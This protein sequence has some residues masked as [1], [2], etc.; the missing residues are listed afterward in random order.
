MRAPTAAEQS[1]SSRGRLYEDPAAVQ[2]WQLISTL[3]GRLAAMCANRLFL[4]WCSCRACLLSLRFQG[5]TLPS[6]PHSYSPVNPHH[7]HYALPTVC[8]SWDD[9]L[10]AHPGPRGTWFP[11]ARM[12]ADEAV[13][14]GFQTAARRLAPLRDACTWDNSWWRRNDGLAVILSPCLS[15]PCISS[16]SFAGP[17]WDEAGIQ[18]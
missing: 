8:G 2:A 14:L 17:E 11:A 15:R 18:R 10:G 12:S 3:F 13:A 6:P 1:G 4:L 16:G 9:R 5:L 7:R